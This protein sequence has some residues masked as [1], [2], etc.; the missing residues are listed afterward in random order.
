M[1]GEC[2]AVEQVLEW[3]RAHDCTDIEIRFDY[4]GLAHW[5]NGTWRT[6]AVRTQRYRERVASSGVRITWTKIQAHNG[7]YGNARVD[8]F[9]RHA[10]TNHVFF[11]EL[12]LSILPPRL[13]HSQVTPAPGQ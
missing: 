11:P 12:P 1:A 2:H 13:R 4:T 7:E 8:F 10:A 5:A 9:A 6:N 3:C